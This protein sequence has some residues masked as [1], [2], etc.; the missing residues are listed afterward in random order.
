M[1]NKSWEL[2]QATGFGVTEHLLELLDVGSRLELIFVNTD[3]TPHARTPPDNLLCACRPSRPVGLTTLALTRDEARPQQGLT[4]GSTQRRRVVGCSTE[5][6]GDA[7]CNV[8][9]YERVNPH[10]ASR[11]TSRSANQ[12]CRTPRARTA[13]WCRH[14]PSLRHAA[15]A[16]GTPP[17]ARRHARG[18][19]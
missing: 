15:S 5:F 7:G 4:F 16:S 9:M 3:D 12:R 13:T 2:Q 6:C 10:A 18:S 17:P 8:E 14:E 1:R 11:H 19:P